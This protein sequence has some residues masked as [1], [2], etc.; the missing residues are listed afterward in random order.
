DVSRAGQPQGCRQ[1][2]R[3]R[4]RTSIWFGRSSEPDECAKDRDG[5]SPALHLLSIAWT[6]CPS[7]T[8]CLPA[9]MTASFEPQPLRISTFSPSSKPVVRA[10]LSAFLSRT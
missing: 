3:Q 5:G 2:D 10:T 9:T 1:I 7:V 4:C 6:F 8:D